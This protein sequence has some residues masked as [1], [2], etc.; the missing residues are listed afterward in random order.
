VPR[1]RPTRLVA[2]VT[3]LVISVVVA[4]GVARSFRPPPSRDLALSTHEFTER[5]VGRDAG[6]VRQSLGKPDLAIPTPSTGPDDHAERWNYKAVHFAGSEP[7]D[8]AI[9]VGTDGKVVRILFWRDRKQSE[10]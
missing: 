1:A 9:H 10:E 3:L 4:A 7:C 5:F 8:V 6:E 2:L